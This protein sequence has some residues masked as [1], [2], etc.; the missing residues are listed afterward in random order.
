MYNQ[1]KFRSLYFRVTDF[2]HQSK[3]MSK[4]WDV[5]TKGCHSKGMSKQWD[6]KAKGCQRY[7]VSQQW[8]V[9]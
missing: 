9:K 7:G 3:G 8:D 1:R 6:V 5:K 4:Q 2:E